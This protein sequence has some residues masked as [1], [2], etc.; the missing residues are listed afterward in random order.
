MSAALKA[1]HATLRQTPLDDDAKRG[2]Y[3]Q[4]T[5]KVSAK[6]MSDAERKA[7]TARLKQLYP[8]TAKPF[9]KAAKPYQRKIHALWKSCAQKGVIRDGSRAALRTFVKNE[10]GVDD[11]DF[12][13]WQQANP[14]IEALKKME[15]RG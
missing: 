7:V 15:E 3:E 13:D 2:L 4:L 5:G 11:P 14:I 6:D 8:A 1:L 10:S 12:L 9:K